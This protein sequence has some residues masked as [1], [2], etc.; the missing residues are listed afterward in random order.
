MERKQAI[1]LVALGCS[2][3]GFLGVCTRHFFALGLN[4][5]DISFIRQSLTAAALFVI[6]ILTDRKV[7]SVDRKDILFLVA[8][9]AVKLLSDIALFKAQENTTLALSALLQMTFPY[10]TLILSLFIFH[11]KITSRKL[12]AMFVAFLD[13]CWSPEGSSTWTTATPSVSSA[14]CSPDCASDCTSSATASTSE[15]GG[16]RRHSCSTVSSYPL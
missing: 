12:M 4:S 10:Y 13:A 5:F 15:K 3:F 7:L 2:L 6:I 16:T 9:G 8:F 11:E 14:H 1:L